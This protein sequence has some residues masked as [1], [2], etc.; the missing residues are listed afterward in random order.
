MIDLFKSSLDD[1][2]SVCPAPL[3]ARPLPAIPPLRPPVRKASAAMDEARIGKGLKFKGKIGGASPLYIEGSVEGSIY[4]PDHL[5]TVG[6]SG[7]VAASITAREVLVLGKVWGNITASNRLEIRAQGAVIGDVMATRLSIEEG[8]Y[9]KGRVT[10]LKTG[11]ETAEE[12]SAGAT[13]VHSA[14]LLVQSETGKP[15]AVPVPVPLSA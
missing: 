3:L 15:R 13:E 12:K 6:P 8:A 4:L 14:R 7:D 1:I 9:V 10:H 11:P 5:V 2:P